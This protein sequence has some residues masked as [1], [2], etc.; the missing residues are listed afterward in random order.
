MYKDN[1][2]WVVLVYKITAFKNIIRVNQHTRSLKNET[3]S[4]KKTLVNT[5]TNDFCISAYVLSGN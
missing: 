4:N 2:N 5:A 1:I 3:D